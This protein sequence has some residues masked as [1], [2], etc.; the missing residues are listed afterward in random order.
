MK[1]RLDSA[2]A[3]K[4]L[5]ETI[6]NARARI[7]A[8]QVRVDGETVVKAGRKISKENKIE[9]IKPREFVSRGGEKLSGALS[10]FGIDVSGM[11]A[12]D[13]GASTGG[14]TDCLLRCGCNRVFAVDVGYGTLAWKLRNDPRVRCIEKKNAR[15]LKPEDIGEQVDMV[16][17]DVSF[18]SAALILP[19]AKQLIKPSG[20]IIVLVKPQFELSRE[21]VGKGGVVKELLLQQE[22]VE[23]VKSAALQTVLAAVQVSPSGLKGPKGNQE[24]FVWFKPC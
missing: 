18:I 17:I 8:G 21:K 16:T 5:A 15:Y 13:I 23:K 3:E 19:V 14:F 10:D 2:L 9:I 1:K 24:W 22:A 4:G 12:V 11:V 6:D 20:S 7:M